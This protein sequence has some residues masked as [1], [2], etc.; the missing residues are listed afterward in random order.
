M[1]T[2]MTMKTKE[3]RRAKSLGSCGLNKY[4]MHTFLTTVDPAS[5]FKQSAGFKNYSMECH[6]ARVI[7]QY[8]G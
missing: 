1:T 2:K 5:Y 6:I 8:H 4:R 7:T 3:W